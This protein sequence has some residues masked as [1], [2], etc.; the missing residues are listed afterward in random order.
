MIWHLGSRQS[1]VVVRHR[2]EMVKLTRAAELLRTILRRTQ[3]VSETPMRRNTQTVRTTEAE[4]R[5]ADARALAR[6]AETGDAVTVESLLAEGVPVDVPLSKGETALMRASARGFETVAQLLLAAGADASAR[7][8]DGFTPLTLATFFGHAQIAGLLLEHGADAST[9][10]RLG[11][12]ARTW[13][14]ARGFSELSSL[15]AAAESDPRRPAVTVE[16]PGSHQSSPVSP[17][18]ASEPE[19]AAV[20]TQPQDV[21]RNPV[22]ELLI[23]SLAPDAPGVRPASERARSAEAELSARAAEVS[24]VFGAKPANVGAAESDDTTEFE[25]GRRLSHDAIAGAA[26]DASGFG[27]AGEVGR[28]EMFATFQPARSGRSWQSIVGLLLLAVACTTA[29]YAAWRAT[30]PGQS[31]AQTVASP[32]AAGAQPVVPLTEAQSDAAAQPS[33]S[34]TP[35]DAQSLESPVTDPGFFVPYGTAPPQP[36]QP[37]AVYP[38]G[39]SPSVPALAS[40]EGRASSAEPSNARRADADE[41]RPSRSLRSTAS[42]ENSGDAASGGRDS[43]ANSPSQDAQP[44]IIVPAPRPAP[45]PSEPTATPTPSRKVIQWPPS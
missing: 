21:R 38:D 17:R 44:V 40:E 3:S 30:S 6:A 35:S 41:S 31:P 28:G 12:T 7:R 23:A 14:D 19:H 16:Q 5:E 1:R 36:V 22:A 45:A 15:I 10:T 9:P 20:S 37:Y 13:A 34:V 18:D 2:S 33:P 27:G 39:A 25:E 4:P 42:E 24:Q 32:Q 43:R 11:T 29:I 8:A 26:S